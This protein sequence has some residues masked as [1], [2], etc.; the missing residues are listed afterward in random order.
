ML[1]SESQKFTECFKT[2]APLSAQIGNWREILKST[3]IESFPR[4]RIRKKSKQIINRQV[5]KLIKER[6]DMVRNLETEK[7]CEK[8]NFG[9]DRK[10]VQD[11]HMKSE[12]QLRYIKE[13]ESKISNIEA[14]ENRMK[15]V[16][17][18][19]YFSENP[20]NIEMSKMWKM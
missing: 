11:E 8:S 4:I 16:E 2:N 13:I 15:I 17:N 19:K 10:G 14:E 20:E 7:K 6:N 12:Q 1:T 3:I 9:C 18:F 5:S